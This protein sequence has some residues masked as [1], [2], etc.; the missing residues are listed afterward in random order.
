MSTDFLR[1]CSHTV[2][3][4]LFSE[5]TLR[6]LAVVG[7]AGG[8]LVSQAAFMTLTSKEVVQLGLQFRIWHQLGICGKLVLVDRCRAAIPWWSKKQREASLT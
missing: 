5:E 2:C 7:R 3:I 1:P 4:L 6:R 8:Q